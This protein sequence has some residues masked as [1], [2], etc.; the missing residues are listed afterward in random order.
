MSAG[1]VDGRPMKADEWDFTPR[2][3]E[4]LNPP[5]VYRCERARDVGDRLLQAAIN[6]V[7]E[8]APCWQGTGRIALVC[9]HMLSSAVV[10]AADLLAARRTASRAPSVADIE[11]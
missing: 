10:Y 3:D 8:L 7:G 1:N 2:E 6:S 5:D 4:L 11:A 9:A